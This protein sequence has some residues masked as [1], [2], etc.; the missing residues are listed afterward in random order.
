MILLMKLN[1]AKGLVKLTSSG[2]EDGEKERSDRVNLILP[3]CLSF[4]FFFFVCDLPLLAV[5]IIFVLFCHQVVRL[6]HLVFR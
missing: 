4:F 5:F 3:P 6:I 1:G 2:V